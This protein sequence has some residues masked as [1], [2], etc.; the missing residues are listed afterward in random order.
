MMCF[1]CLDQL[2]GNGMFID[3]DDNPSAV[4]LAQVGKSLVVVEYAADRLRGRSSAS[5]LSS[6]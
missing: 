3:E 2:S 4:R 5:A 6:R 1:A